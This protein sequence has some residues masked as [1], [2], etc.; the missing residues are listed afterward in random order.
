MAR[1]GAG[2]KFILSAGEIGAYT[3]CP[4]AWRLQ[5]VERVKPAYSETIR[6]GEEAHAEWAR[7]YDKGVLL[8][9][10]AKILLFLLL[11]AT[12][13]VVALIVLT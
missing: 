9:R 12:C 2:G 3:V 6:E 1:R 4:E 8:V 7:T 5:K 13:L 10:D 11:A